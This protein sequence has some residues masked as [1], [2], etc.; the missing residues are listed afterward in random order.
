MKLLVV[1]DDE[2]LRLTVKL[3][4]ESRGYQVDEACDGQEAVEI[5]SKGDHSYRVVLLDVNMPRM[6]GLQ[7]LEKIKEL[8]PEIICLILTAHSDVKDAVRAIKAGAYDYLEKPVDAGQILEMLASAGEA[9]ALVEAVA[10]SAPTVHFDE[11]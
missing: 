9:N 7:A 11:G 1:D 2:T 5:I 10:F 3:A 8:S 4:L 6:D